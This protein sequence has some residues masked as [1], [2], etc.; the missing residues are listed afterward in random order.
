MLEPGDRVLVAVS[1]GKD[2][3][4]VWDILLDARLP[5]RRPLPRPRASATTATP[6]ARWPARSPADRGLHAHRGRPARP[7]TAST[8]RPARKAAKRVPC[9]ACGLSKR[10]L[11]DEARPH[12]RLRRRRHRPQPR[13]R[14]GRAV[15]QRAA[16]ADRLPRPPAARAAGPPRLPQEGQ[17]ARAPGRAGDGGLLR[18]PGH[19]LHRRGVPDGRRQQAPRLQGGAQR[20]RGHLAGHASTT[21]TSASSPGPPS[22]FTPEAEAEQEPL[23]RCERCGAPTP[24]EVCAFCRLRRARRRGVR[25]RA[26]RAGTARDDAAPFAVGEQVLLIDTKKRRYLLILEPGKEFHSH[27]GIVGHDAL[28]GSRRGHHRS[29]RRTGCTT[30]RSARPWPT[31][32]SRCPAARR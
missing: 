25:R 10:H 13:R 3:L 28:I 5:G 29:A 9:S 27:S 32:C 18:A 15:R 21:S 17:A 11:F 26:R 30:R 20:H 16:L 4:A 14:G 12:R 24:G 8:S 23:R 22:D 1:G 7:T 6:P 31:S 2:S 19:R